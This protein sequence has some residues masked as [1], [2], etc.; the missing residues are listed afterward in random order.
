MYSSTA[1]REAH[2]IAYTNANSL[3]LRVRVTV[4][5]LGFMGLGFRV[6]V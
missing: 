2:G 1:L 5:V 3:I 4:R 6:I